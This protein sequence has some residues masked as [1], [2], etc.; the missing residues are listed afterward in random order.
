MRT[1]YATKKLFPLRVPDSSPLDH[2]RF[3]IFVA[4]NMDSGPVTHP[5]TGVES[6]ARRQVEVDVSSQTS[7]G[8]KKAP[9]SLKK[10]RDDADYRPSDD[11]ED[12]EEEEEEED[13]DDKG[14]P[15]T[16]RK[17]SE[18]PTS[19]STRPTPSTSQTALFSAAAAPVQRPQEGLTVSQA[20]TLSPSAIVDLLEP[21][22]VDDE[23][24]RRPLPGGMCPCASALVA[25]LAPC[26]F[27]HGFFLS[28]FSFCDLPFLSHRSLPR[29][30]STPACSNLLYTRMPHRF[31][32]PFRFFSSVFALCSK[33][34]NFLLAVVTPT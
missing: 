3:S 1:K 30:H 22:R 25:S 27:W 19:L 32:N 21:T 18:S 5:P 24:Q 7:D 14:V 16:T 31:P 10:D 28:F 15:T 33:K 13:D 4:I 9:T 6:K 8:T 2:F 20:R 26:T 23:S 34:K 12:D 29:A 11:E 17:E